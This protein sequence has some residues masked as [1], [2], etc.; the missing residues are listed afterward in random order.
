MATF[1]TQATLRY[2]GGVVNSNIATGELVDPLTVTK[3]SPGGTYTPGESLT[4][5]IGI[6]NS[7]E[8]AVTGLTVEDDL[9]AITFGA[10]TLRALTYEEG[11]VLYYRNGAVQPA[12]AVTADAGGLTFTGIAV[13]AGGDAVLIYRATVSPYAAPG[14]GGTIT[15]TVSV[16]NGTVGPITAEETVSAAAA[17]RLTIDKGLAPR[18]VTEN[19]RV[20]Y[21]FTIGNLGNTAATATDGVTVTDTFLPVLS[22]LVVT[23]DGETLTAGTDYTYAPATGEFATTAGRITVPAA[24]FTQNATTGAWQTVPGTAVLTVTGTI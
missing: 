14:A 20:T 22:D 19:G 17:P 6:V 7:G 12:P 13:P 23:L 24:A 16:R 5:A 10:G 1:T 8:A 9:G 21:T 4:Y 15:N 2:T 11:S 18:T 3:T